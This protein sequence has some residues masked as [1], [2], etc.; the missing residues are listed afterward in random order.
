[1]QEKPIEVKVSSH[2]EKAFEPQ[3]LMQMQNESKLLNSKLASNKQVS[4]SLVKMIYSLFT[5]IF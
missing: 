2:S 4:H 5:S 1:M 3:E